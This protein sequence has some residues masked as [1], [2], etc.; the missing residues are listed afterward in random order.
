MYNNVFATPQRICIES[1]FHEYYCI[2]LTGV[3]FFIYNWYYLVN[4]VKVMAKHK[5]NLYLE[6]NIIDYLKSESRRLGIPIG[7]I[8]SIMVDE[9][10]KSEIKLS[11]LPNFDGFLSAIED[12]P[13]IFDEKDRLTIL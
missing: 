2:I 5:L 12:V 7:A 3:W 8:V 11:R 9:R 6:K 10:H 4:G 13:S 1:L